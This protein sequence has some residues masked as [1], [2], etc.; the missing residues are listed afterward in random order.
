V[1]A[2]APDAA[3][4]LDIST[5]AA[6]GV[7]LRVRVIPRASGDAIAGVRDGALLVRVSAPPVEGRANEALVRLLSRRLEVPR[8]RIEVV[9][10]LSARTKRVRI[11]GATLEA[12]GSLAPPEPG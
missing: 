2:G 9:A 12:L 11:Q 6:G 4:R 1:S 10:G 7:I 8:S 5:D 3:G